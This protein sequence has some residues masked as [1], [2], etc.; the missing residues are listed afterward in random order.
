[1]VDL[2]EL[3]K[4]GWSYPV[5]SGGIITEGSDVDNNG[6]TDIYKQLATDSTGKQMWVDRKELVYEVTRVYKAFLGATDTNL[7]ITITSDGSIDR[8]ENRRRVPYP[9]TYFI[10]T[11]NDSE[12]KAYHD[13]TLTIVVGSFT[14]DFNGIAVNLV[15]TVNRMGAHDIVLNF[16]SHPGIDVDITVKYGYLATTTLSDDKYFPTTVP[17][18]Q[19]ASVGQVIAVKSVDETGK[20]T[21]WET[22]NNTGGA[23]GDSS[24]KCFIIK[25]TFVES[26]GDF[27]LETNMT[28][29]EVISALEAGELT[30]AK[31]MFAANDLNDPTSKHH[32]FCTGTA[33]ICT[34]YDNYV[35]CPIL[36]ITT[37][38]IV[39]TGS[40]A[41]QVFY[42]DAQGI[43]ETPNIT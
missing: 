6:L 29:E 34:F 4:N 5:S 39:E 11:L 18:I 20:P 10:V 24:G 3:M 15:R 38:G 35:A 31:Y 14:F 1:M 26:S 2:R 40:P 42:L 21:E 19:S 8:L 16:A 43:F 33:S 27:T 22:V 9:G 23:G 17:V 13:E 12:Y 41:C 25:K 7:K 36:K 37:Y 28:Y 32:C 30:D